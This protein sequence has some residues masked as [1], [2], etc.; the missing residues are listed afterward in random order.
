MDTV[1]IEIGVSTSPVLVAYLHDFS[2]YLFFLI[3]I[4]IFFQFFHL[5]TDYLRYRGRRDG[6]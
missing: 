4:L 6:H 3:H 1:A 2:S 5:V